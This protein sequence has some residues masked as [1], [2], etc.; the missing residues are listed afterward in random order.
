[1]YCSG[2]ENKGPFQYHMI[3]L[4]GE[5]TGPGEFPTQRPVTRSFD[6]FF[7]LRLNKRLNK[8]PRWLVIWDAIVVIMTSVSCD[9]TC[10]R[11][12]NHPRIKTRFIVLIGLP[13]SRHARV[14]Q[15]PCCYQ[16]SL[17]YERQMMTFLRARIRCQGGRH[18]RCHVTT[19]ILRNVPIAHLESGNTSILLL[20]SYLI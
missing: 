18:F 3:H 4:S 8:Q 7:D 17:S 2:S 19:G 15:T 9:G 6:V 11:V 1:M 13:N 16:E 5:F 20:K 12:T 14:V 10:C